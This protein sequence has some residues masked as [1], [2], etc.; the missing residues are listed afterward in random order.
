MFGH[1]GKGTAMSGSF[2]DPLLSQGIRRGEGTASLAAKESVTSQRPQQL[3]AER[4]ACG[5]QQSTFER[6][7]DWAAWRQHSLRTEELSILRPYVFVPL[8]EEGLFL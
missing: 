4:E 6:I 3:H 7:G 5:L 8:Q 1:N 2:E